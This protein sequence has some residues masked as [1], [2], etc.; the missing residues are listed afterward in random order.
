MS[1]A[2][3]AITVTLTAEDHIALGLF[4]SD[5]PYL[6]RSPWRI[7]LVMSALGILAPWVSLPFFGWRPDPRGGAAMWPI[8]AAMAV[9]AALW[10][11]SLP[12][13][14]RWR[15]RRQYRAWFAQRRT[16]LSG[17]R[18]IAPRVDGLFAQGEQGESRFA[19]SIVTGIVETPAHLFL[20][21]GET[22]AHLIPKRDVPE[23][24][25]QAFRDAVAAD[26]GLPITPAR[27]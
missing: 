4:L 1:D 26:S 11:V 6:R 23:A 24:A 7:A 8:S 2:A 27:G 9:V 14:A 13:L 10:L 19:W 5:K 17:P 18:D 22:N 20:M 25:M 12:A 3:P 21:A 16:L 15:L